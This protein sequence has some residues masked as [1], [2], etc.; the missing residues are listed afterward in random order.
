M[1]CTSFASGGGDKQKRIL[2]N[3]PDDFEKYTSFLCGREPETVMQTLTEMLGCDD[4]ITKVAV[5]ATHHT[6]TGNVVLTD[7]AE[8]SAKFEI[9]I[10]KDIV[11]GESLVE[12]K[13]LG[14][15]AMD[16]LA[17]YRECRVHLNN[18]F[19]DFI[20]ER[21]EALSND[22]FAF[23]APIAEKVVDAAVVEGWIR[24]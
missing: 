5:S 21:F 9:N 2:E 18:N 17:F 6:I 24:R 16:F 23:A 4:K 20:V 1:H 13:R 7:G 12:Y 8:T 22:I 19:E 15:N 14:G 11:T 3:T 10:Y